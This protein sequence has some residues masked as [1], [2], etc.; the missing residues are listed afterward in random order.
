LAIRNP[1]GIV[2]TPT[3]LG[4]WPSLAR[5]GKDVSPF[6]ID[7]VSLWANLASCSSPGLTS[8]RESEHFMEVSHRSS[9]NTSGFAFLLF[10][11]FLLV[12]YYFRL[13]ERFF[14]YSY[15]GW[16]FGVLYKM[17]MSIPQMLDAMLNSVRNS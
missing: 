14:G 5:L 16:M 15:I 2:A 1:S 6:K 7:I 17:A 10:V 3:I 11:A 12:A 9:V 4:R 8:P 13:E